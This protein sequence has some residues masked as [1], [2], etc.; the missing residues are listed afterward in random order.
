MERKALALLAGVL[1]LAGSVVADYTVAPLVGGL[2]SADAQPGQSVIVDLS[3]SSDASPPDACTSAIFTVSF[4]QPGLQY[5]AY[6]WAAPFTNAGQDDWASPASAAL[7][8][9]VSAT[10]WIDPMS[11][12]GS[13]DIYFENFVTGQDTSFS[14]GILL[15]L[16]I[17]IPGDFPDGQV[18]ISVVPDTF[19]SGMG[20][21]GA[22]GQTLTLNVSSEAE[23]PGD[24]D[25][26]GFVG[27][28]DLDIILDNWGQSVPPAQEIADLDDSGF[29]G[30]GDLDIVLD[31]WGQS[32]E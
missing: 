16:D 12:P 30:Q 9:S 6:A 11:D 14:E 21:I 13:D 18:L 10:T 17:T 15:S 25:G 1:V 22:A 32:A 8:E 2:S 31:H 20:S 28:G 23:L 5:D 4:S 24:A 27:Q 7:P 19:D 26:S 3:V 29:I